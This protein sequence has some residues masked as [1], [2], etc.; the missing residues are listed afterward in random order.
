MPSLP[1]QGLRRHLEGEEAA[2]GEAAAEG[3][4]GNSTL[5]AGAGPPDEDTAALGKKQFEALFPAAFMSKEQIQNG[6]FIVYFL[7]K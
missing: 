7:G 6:G 2:G 4:G 5:Q 3:E 1:I